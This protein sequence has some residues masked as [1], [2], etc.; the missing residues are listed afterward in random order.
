MG[1]YTLFLDEELLSPGSAGEVSLGAK[2]QGDGIIVLPFLLLHR[3]EDHSDP[4]EASPVVARVFP[5]R[6]HC[7]D[8]SLLQRDVAQGLTGK[9][10]VELLFLF[11]S[12]SSTAERSPKNQ[13]AAFII[14]TRASSA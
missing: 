4:G 7:E 14:D 1:D 2:G 3:V 6:P 9:V 13:V 12:S 5:S 8:A 10:E 11:S